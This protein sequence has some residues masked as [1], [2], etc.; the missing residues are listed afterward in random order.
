MSAC[1]QDMKTICAL[2]GLSK[3]MNPR[4]GGG[5]VRYKK[6]FDIVPMLSVGHA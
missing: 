4:T 2:E 6:V 3:A 1:A 5:I